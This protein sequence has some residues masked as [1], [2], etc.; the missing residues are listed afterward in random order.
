MEV[1]TKNPE[2]MPQDEKEEEVM[3]E[4]AD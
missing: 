1:V 4:G 3:F 2:V